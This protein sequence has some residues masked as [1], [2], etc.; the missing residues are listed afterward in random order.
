MSAQSLSQPHR[1]CASEDDSSCDL[2]AMSH[3]RSEPVPFLQGTVIFLLP[4][5]L[6]SSRR[7]QILAPEI[8]RKGGEVTDDPSSA[9]HCI[10]PCT[11]VE[12]RRKELCA[13]YGVPDSCKCVPDS[14]LFTEPDV[15][16]ERGAALA[17]KR[18][19]GQ[20][21]SHTEDLMRDASH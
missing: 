20:A 8:R 6:M 4:T 17:Q 3:R 10:V 12:E 18:P 15:L 14:F 5:H 1:G 21:M 7:R 19:W 9:T 11:A 16:Q 13:K 2:K